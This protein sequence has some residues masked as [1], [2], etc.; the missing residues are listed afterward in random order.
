[1]TCERSVSNSNTNFVYSPGTSTIT[2]RLRTETS[3][4]PTLL[5]GLNLLGRIY[6]QL[7]QISIGIDLSAGVLYQYSP[8]NY[9][10]VRQVYQDDVLIVET[11]LTR[12]ALN[13]SLRIIN[14]YAIGVQYHFNLKK[15]KEQPVEID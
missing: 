1:M 4:Y 14:N 9:T 8:P 5:Y 7:G 13:N 10:S 11:E 6:Y 15:K 2:G 12:Q 3:S